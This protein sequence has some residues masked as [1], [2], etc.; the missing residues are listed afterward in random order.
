MVQSLSTASY[1]LT[2]SN[3]SKN[4]KRPQKRTHIYGRYSLTQFI[5]LKDVISAFERY[6]NKPGTVI[7]KNNIIC[8]PQTK[9][10]SEIGTAF[11]Y[12]LVLTLYRKHKTLFLSKIEFEI[13]DR[14]AHSYEVFEYGRIWKKNKRYLKEYAYGKSSLNRRVLKAFIVLARLVSMGRAIFSDPMPYLEEIEPLALEDLKALLSL[15][16][17]D[18]FTP[19]KYAII[20][21]RFGQVGTW[22]AGADGDLIV[23]GTLIDVKTVQ[24]MP[25]RAWEQLAG[26]YLLHK[27]NGLI[28]SENA[29]EHNHLRRLEYSKARSKELIRGHERRIKMFRSHIV[30][31]I[32][33][34]KVACYFSRHGL[35]QEADV[36]SLICNKKNEKYLWNIFTGKTKIKHPQQNFF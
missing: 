36:E 27:N 13:A 10:Y 2:T 6:T 28:S 29:E 8:K 23:D 25:V 17:W 32:R 19:K 4:K 12:L 20:N 3:P 31:K 22:I 21:P 18:K 34:S 33:I 14:A 9:T 15:V 26:Y 7:F 1:Q 24:K 35:F 16:P 5:A 11:E 30:R